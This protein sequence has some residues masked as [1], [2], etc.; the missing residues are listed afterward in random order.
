MYHSNWGKFKKSSSVTSNLPIIPPAKGSIRIPTDRPDWIADKGVHFSL[1]NKG[2]YSVTAFST[3][4]HNEHIALCQRAQKLTPIADDELVVQFCAFVKNNFNKLFPGFKRRRPVS[5]S[6]YLENSNASP[7][8]K[9]SILRAGNELLANGVDH[10]TCLNK[11]ELHLMT[12]RKMFIKVENNLY[13]SPCGELLKAP[14]AIQGADPKFIALVGPCFMALQAELKKCWDGKNFPILFSSGVDSVKLAQHVDVPEWQIFKNDVSSYDASICAAICE[15]EVWM[16]GKMG[17]RRVVRDLMRANI[18][19]HGVSSKG[20]K[21]KV[22]GTRKS[23]DP[24]TTYFNSIINGLLHLFVLTDR[25]TLELSNVLRRIRMLVAG[26]DNLLRHCRTLIPYWPDM[27]LLGFK[28]DNLYVSTLD[29]ADFCSSKIYRL[30]DKYTFAPMLGRVIN[31]L[32]EFNNPP[33]K[34]DPFS[35]IRGVVLGLRAASTVVPF[36]WDYLKWVLVLTKGVPVWIPPNEEWKMTYGM[37]LAD[38]PDEINNQVVVERDYH[39]SFYH[40]SFVMRAVPRELKYTDWLSNGVV[41]LLF[42]HD[43]SAPQSIFV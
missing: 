33:A 1:I 29:R 35:I 20:I 18:S 14:R 38:P 15:L 19:T 30:I 26:D 36:M 5:L 9:Q 34:I 21:Y 43:T 24:Y 23:G 3:N 42:D 10:D 13:N 22:N 28:C 16:A 25:G 7:A 40:H 11:N 6:N 17:A 39:Y 27:T 4:G 12:K 32:F 2:Q 37:L 41:E 8:V 31:K